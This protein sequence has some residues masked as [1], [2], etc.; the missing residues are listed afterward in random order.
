MEIRFATVADTANVSREG[1]LNITG[2]FTTI[3][4]AHD[5]PVHWPSM[6]LVIILETDA[7][8]V[9]EH[10]LEIKFVDA[11]GEVLQTQGGTFDAPQPSTP[12]FP[13][14]IQFVLSYRGLEFP[15][16]GDYA[17]D[18]FIDDRYGDTVFLHVK[19]REE[20]QG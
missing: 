14:R 13:Q 1:K 19:S 5:P 6:D 9:G 7:S 11:D 15:R 18:I 12:G 10:S 17:F 4:A 3:W 20:A 8:E 2:M 16:F